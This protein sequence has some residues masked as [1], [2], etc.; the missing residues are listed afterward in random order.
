MDSWIHGSMDEFMNPLTYGSIIDIVD[1]EGTV[2]TAATVH[3]V[4]IVNT[5][6]TFD[7]VHS[8]PSVHDDHN[9]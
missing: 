2:D 6:H 8:A 9:L 1:T 3:I 5:V 7:I 4:D